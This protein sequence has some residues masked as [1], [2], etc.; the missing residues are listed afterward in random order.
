MFPFN[1]L[2]DVN[3]LQLRVSDSVS[4]YSEKAYRREQGTFFEAVGNVVI[5]SGDDTLYGEK[6][7][8]NTKTGHVQ[9]EGSV[10][11]IGKSITVYGSK[12]VYNMYSQS[13]EM[14]N[15][16]MITPEFSIIASK[17]IKKSQDEYQAI[18]AEFTTCRDCTES[19]QIYGKK[20]E[21]ELNQ[22][23]QIH[24]ALVKVKGIDVLY[25]P[26]IALPIKN[27]RESGVLFPK[28]S[29]RNS[30]GVQYEQPF[31]WA[32]DQDKDFTFTPTFL[33]QRGYG[34]DLEYRHVLSEK[35][36]FEFSN[37]MVQ[38]LIYLPEK[39]TDDT[40]ET[41]YF[42]HF[43]EFES[44]QQWSHSLTQH[45]HILGSKDLDFF[46]DYS[47][48]TE[49]YLRRTD[50]GLDMFLEKRFQEY[51]L[52][53]EVDY[54][55]NILFSDTEEFDTNYVQTLPSVYFSMLP[56]MIWQTN[57]DYFYK[58]SYGLDGDFST[59]K[60]NKQKEDQFL[61]NA[62]RLDLTPYLD[63][64]ILN[65]G[66]FILKSKYKVDYQ[67]YT[68]LDDENKR[69]FKES[70]LVSTE[71]SFTIDKIF[72][73]AYEEVYDSSE[74]A[75]ED[76]ERISDKTNKK[77]NV[78]NSTIIGDLPGIESIYTKEKIDVKRNSYRHS[79]EFKFIHHQLVHGKE[80]GN[81]TFN[82]QIKNEEGWFDYRDAITED[83]LTLNSDEARIKIPLK[84][85]LEFQ[86]NNV[87]VKKTARRFRY[88]VDEKYLKDNFEYKQLGFFNISQ[89]FLMDGSQESDQ[90]EDK[91]T[92][93]Y[94]HSGYQASSWNLSLKD[95]FIHQS[96]NH[97][98][99]FSGQKNFDRLSFLTQY[100]LNTF[101]NSSLKTLK[102]GT[103]FRPFDVLGFSILKEH[104]LDSDEN[105]SSI[106]QMDFMP[107]NNC[108][109]LNLNYKENIVEKRFG[110]KFRF[111]FGNEEF[112]EYRNNFFSFNRLGK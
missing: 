83:L 80:H 19:W 88:N 90:I 38:D 31:Y 56:K 30:E 70:G 76:L 78:L 9:I 77:D 29:T 93:L 81:E 32:I 100:N 35:S 60:Q 42:R 2:A 59:F 20:V 69:F 36:W 1:V 107:H 96:G 50:Y 15:A 28:V 65:K 66:P 12:I 47:Y 87:L 39:L 33:S 86:W 23:V 94:L 10:R 14:Y 89:G 24:H 102:I 43:W 112:K 68:F 82:E 46:R 54:K 8:L 41:S 40:S 105:I 6:A 108:W 97:I 57:E 55:R 75:E 111:N 5:S 16:Q 37:K 22:Y 18:E 25:L 73:L 49:D 79:Q 7:S 101:S 84:N 58:L 99:S 26:Y 98:L 52:G 4:I 53:L 3:T 103:Q 44:H 51:S 27:K 71:V 17:L 104:D 64:N 34:L 74:L 95:Y 72:G 109:I 61:R 91:L 106:Y 85:T 62:H 63:L 21:I 11:Y 48:F 92:R 13:L 110:F 67:E 45:L